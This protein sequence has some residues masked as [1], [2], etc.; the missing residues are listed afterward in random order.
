VSARPLFEGSARAGSLSV[1]TDISDLKAAERAL[2]QNMELLEQRVR[3]R[4]REL[5]VLYRVTA[6]ASESLDLSAGLGRSLEEMLSAVESSA[7]AIHLLDE[8]RQ[9]LRLA[10]QQGLPS[11]L[12]EELAEA[13]LDASLPGMAI[14]RRE[15]VVV[16]DSS[17]ARGRSTLS[18]LGVPIR[19][20]GNVLGVLS[21]YGGREER[22]TA[23]EVALLSSA[24]DHIGVAVEN[25]RLRSRAEHAAAMEERERLAQDL[26]DSVTQSLYSL[27]LFTKVALEL[28][29][30]G[31]L[32]R[33]EGNLLDA[34]ESAQQ[35]LKEMRLLVHQ[36]RPSV[37]RQEG[38]AGA[39]RQRLDAVEKRSGVDGR[40]EVHGTGELSEPTELGLYLI[41][42]EALNN[43]L[44]HARAS[45]VTM[46]LDTRAH[47]VRLEIGDD[48]RGFDLASAAESGG[49]GLNNMAER[50][51]RLGGS[52]EID[53]SPGA[54][55]RVR[56]I[57]PRTEVRQELARSLPRRG[58]AG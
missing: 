38:L 16:Q 26:H 12:R 47:E 22:L 9:N 31:D 13:P 11:V 40:L 18:Y 55:T 4:T 8:T 25:A 23:E 33:L 50:A 28:A 30:R 49:M 42:L 44:K 3:D 48:G 19:A 56:V 36:L 6:I 10:A 53:T 7:G 15:P 58:V 24:A 34:T 20:G 1:F 54:G 2:R 5:S 14:T 41:G 52:C 17:S 32:A 57:V 39:F 21:I 29:R 45:A 51:G 43:A 27:T 37:L 35:A 46:L